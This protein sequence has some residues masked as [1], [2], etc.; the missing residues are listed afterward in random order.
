[1]I[2]KE[3]RR[4]VSTAFDAILSKIKKSAFPKARR[5]QSKKKSRE[6]SA[7]TADVPE[8]V[9]SL[10]PV[11]VSAFEKCAEFQ[12]G[13]WTAMGSDMKT[14]GPRSQRQSRTRERRA[15][16]LRQHHLKTGK[17]ETTPRDGVRYLQQD[18]GDE[19]YLAPYAKD[20]TPHYP[21]KGTNKYEA[22]HM[23]NA[24]LYKASHRALWRQS[25]PLADIQVQ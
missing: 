18:F 15:K 4:K 14:L 12:G 3:D 9:T 21:A 20:E 17:L 2:A 24:I 22:G 23:L 25:A 6:E 11:E 5:T 7:A 13:H 16:L 8:R 19:R 10:Y 1:M